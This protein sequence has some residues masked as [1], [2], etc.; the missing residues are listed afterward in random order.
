MPALRRRPVAA[1]IAAATLLFGAPAVAR[2]EPALWVVRDADSTVYLFGT[3]HLL[4]PDLQWNTERVRRA[5]ADSGELWLE[6]A[7]V[8]DPEAMVPLVRQYGIDPSR[9]LSTRLDERQ[10]ARLAEV[11]GRLKLDPAQLEPL[12]PWMAGVTLALLSLQ[13]AGFDPE[14]GVDRVL[15]GRAVAEGDAVRAFETAEQQLQFFDGLSEAQQVAFLMSVVDDAGE[16]ASALDTLAAAWSRGDDAPLEREFVTEMK[17]RYPE[18][19][20]VLLTRRNRAWAARIEQVMAGA[21]VHFV[22]VGAGH[23]V[24]PDSLQAELARRGLR[25][26]R[27]A[28][29]SD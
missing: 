16:G 20:N 18:L 28:S 5:M 1:L 2:A 29:R 26:E 14:A 13:G 10:R 12:K 6:I 19:Y 23:L 22:A 8:D 3:V 21:G 7:E 15:K 27:A 17:A 9:P 11:A 24:G 25:A 4:R